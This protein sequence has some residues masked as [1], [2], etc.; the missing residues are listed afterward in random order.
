VT[1]AA[2]LLAAGCVTVVGYAA[3]WLTRDGAIAAA[4][5]GGLV[6]VSAGL[7]G[8]AFL[9]LFFLSGSLLTYVGRR[10]PSD[11]DEKPQRGRTWR[12][13]VANGG[14]AAVG[15]LLVP[16]AP[17]FG[18]PILIGALAAAQADTW[19][20]EIGGRS[21]TPPRLITT[22]QPVQAGTSGG[23]TVLGTLA[24]IVGAGL[25]GWLA[26]MLH[27]PGSVALAAAAGGLLG[28]LTDSLLGATVQGMYH[29]TRCDTKT[30]H[31]I[32]RCGGTA[33]LVRGWGWMDNDAV[34]LVATGLGAVTAVGLGSMW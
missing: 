3:G 33:S 34:N 28:S 27:V 22:G 14:W 9:A 6:L 17:A 31:P 26:W 2:A 24:G 19:G 21:S 18:W 10:G 8:L 20:T 13:V 25:M 23:V 7:A 16:G 4:I 15:A 1:V 5:V 11:S 29:C 30:E 12:Q 32:H